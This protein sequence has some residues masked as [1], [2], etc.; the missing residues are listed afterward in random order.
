MQ[1]VQQF[2][3]SSRVP[4]YFACMSSWLTSKQSKQSLQEVEQGTRQE[5]M[6]KKQLG[7][8]QKLMKE[9][10]QRTWQESMQENQ[11]GTTE[12]GTQYEGRNQ[13]R[14]MQEKYQRTMQIARR[15]FSTVHAKRQAR[16]VAEIY[17]SRGM[18]E[19]Y[20]RT[21]QIA[22]RKLPSFLPSSL[23]ISLHSFSPSFFYISCML[24]PSSFLLFCVLSSYFHVTYNISLLLHCL[25][26]F[27]ATS[28]LFF[29]QSLLSCSLAW[30]ILLFLHNFFANS[31]LR[32]CVLSPLVPSYFSCQ[33]SCIVPSYLYCMLSCLVPCFFFACY[34]SLFLA[35]FFA[36][37]LPTFLL[38]FSHTMLA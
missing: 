5:S 9:K 3:L 17:S 21:M 7:T 23:L 4:C 33:L 15:K 8:R 13:A 24:L 14:G 25:H 18:Q 12:E 27:L 2:M 35:T 16:T 6:Q 29:I 30:L 10:Q 22:R 38:V 1:E 19:K 20:Q 37:S 31:L 26:I 11:Q 34:L 36:C 28:L 32:F